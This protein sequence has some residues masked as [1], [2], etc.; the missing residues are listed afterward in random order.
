MIVQPRRPVRL[1][2]A[3]G[4]IAAVL[5][6]VAARLCQLALVDGHRLAGMARRQ[7]S[8][9]EQV[10]P[11]RGAILDR[12]GEP[13]AMSIHS[14]SVFA[15]PA[16]LPGDGSAAAVARVL[17]IPRVQWL[18]KVST[19]AP[20]T[21]LKR[22]ASP[23]R[24]RS[25]GHLRELLRV[26]CHVEVG[27]EDRHQGGHE[28]PPCRTPRSPDEQPGSSGHL[29][30]SG[31]V[32]HRPRGRDVRGH[33]LL[34][35]PR[36]D[37]VQSSRADEDEA[38]PRPSAGAGSARGGEGEGQVFGSVGLDALQRLLAGLQGLIVG[39]RAARS[40]ILRRIDGSAPVVGA[41]LRTGRRA[42]VLILCLAFIGHSASLPAPGEAKPGVLQ[43]PGG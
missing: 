32:N 33:D 11:L 36:D 37:E 41:S 2:A 23:Q 17:R 6:G 24:P 29:G 35:G 30:H 19:P 9:T 22:Q 43:A 34:V 7:H 20:F 40:R 12:F 31:C 42:A 15:R 18:Q 38:C 8:E 4:M 13:L 10:T 27:G 14:D 21:W 28:P 5:I 25:A 39:R 16:E 1:A 3:C 26:Q